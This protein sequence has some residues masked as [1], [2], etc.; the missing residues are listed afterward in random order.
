MLRRIS[1]E[2]GFSI[3]TAVAV[4][5][6]LV[7]DTVAIQRSQASLL[8]SSNGCVIPLKNSFKKIKFRTAEARLLPIERQEYETW[9]YLSAL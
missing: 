4:Y 2:E 7:L 8:R 6:A 9:H 5:F 3:Y 1:Q